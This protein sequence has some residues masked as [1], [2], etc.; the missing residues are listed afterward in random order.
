MNYTEM[1]SKVGKISNTHLSNCRPND[2]SRFERQQTMNLGEPR[3][4]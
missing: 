3:P 2:I 1:E 4:P